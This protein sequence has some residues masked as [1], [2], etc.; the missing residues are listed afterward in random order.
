MQADA[1]SAISRASADPP[2]SSAAMYFRIRRDVVV[3]AFWVSPCTGGPAQPLQDDVAM[4]LPL[5]LSRSSDA[6]VEP[7]PCET[8]PNVLGSELAGGGRGGGTSGCAADGVET[9]T[10]DAEEDETEVPVVKVA[11]D[12][13]RVAGPG[14]L[15]STLRPVK[16]T[17]PGLRK[18]LSAVGNS[19]ELPRE[20]EPSSLLLLEFEL[21]P[22][23][24]LPPSSSELENMPSNGCSSS[25]LG[26]AFFKADF[27][28]CAFAF[29][30]ALAFAAAP[31][32][33]A[34]LPFVLPTLFPLPKPT[35]WA[36]A[37]TQ[38]PQ[39]AKAS[40][41]PETSFK[42]NISTSVGG[43]VIVI[44][45]TVGVVVVVVVPSMVASMVTS[46]SQSMCARAA[47]T[48]CTMCFR[49][50]SSLSAS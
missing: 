27:A 4:L 37:A 26:D 15:D 38:P 45:I 49:D 46:L 2:L 1:Q 43:K 16:P 42:P 19:M 32:S 34:L 29:V 17:T 21:R 50:S 28:G 20:E 31:A 36:K 6:D 7:P 12:V 3:L 39:A 11:E 44:V 22:L 24:S 25:S 18:P 33:G 35:K 5:P 41:T 40:T 10:L 30:L 47:P 48:S 8:P 14:P 23:L 9:C 13:P